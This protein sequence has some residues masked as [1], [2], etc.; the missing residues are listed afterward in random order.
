MV[1]PMIEN[2]LDPNEDLDPPVWYI[3][4][5]KRQE[6]PYRLYDLK[7][8]RRFTPDTLVWRKGFNEWVAAR[9]VPEILEIFKEEIE[10]KPIHERF[11]GKAVGADLV[12]ESQ[13]TLTLQQDPYQLLLWVLVL[14]LIFLYSYYQF[15]HS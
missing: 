11:K 12:Q 6:G 9:F 10:S 8:N 1:T 4:I 7:R 3:M 14:L 15:Y 5:D 2:K 13:A